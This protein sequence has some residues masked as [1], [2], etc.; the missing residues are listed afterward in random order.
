M[1]HLSAPGIVQLLTIPACLSFSKLDRIVVS[2]PIDLTGPDDEE[3]AKLE[4]H[5][6]HAR[7]VSVEWIKDLGEG[8]TE[9]RM[10]VSSATG[11]LLP[12][13]IVEA[14]LPK[15][16]AKVIPIFPSP[17][18]L[19]RADLTQDVPCFIKWFRSLESKPAVPETSQT[20]SGT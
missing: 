7:Y 15:E 8:R 5:G 12:S 13:F 14:S 20:P 18:R 9:W 10:A 11:G 4:E 17:P 16:I 3:L 1:K 19:H 6:I 2:I